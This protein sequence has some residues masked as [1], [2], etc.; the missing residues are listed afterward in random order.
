M[1]GRVSICSRWSRDWRDTRLGVVLRT[2]CVNMDFESDSIPNARYHVGLT[3][4]LVWW[5]AGIT[6]HL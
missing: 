1:K 5:N 6:I 2:D 4:C 3:L